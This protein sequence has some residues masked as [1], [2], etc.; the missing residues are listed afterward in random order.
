MDE[1]IEYNSHDTW[2][3]SPFGAVPCQT[4]I[5]LSIKVHSEIM[6]NEVLVR[7][8]V[9]NQEEKYKMILER[10]QGD[11]KIYQVQIQAPKEPM[12]IYGSHRRSMLL[13]W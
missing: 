11:T 2:F 6:P 4:H 9:K 12:L 10:D 13:L 3:K 7:L 1:L 5:T 8:W